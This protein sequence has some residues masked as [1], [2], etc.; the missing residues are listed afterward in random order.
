MDVLH[1]GMWTSKAIAELKKGTPYRLAA[2]TEAEGFKRL[3]RKDEIQISPDAS[4]VHICTNNTIEGS[5]WDELP[6]TGGV[7]LVADMSSNIL[8]R[9][10]DVKKFGADFRRRAEKS[11]AV[12]MSPW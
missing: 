2:S 7:P 1:T 3:P 12:G 4:Y 11:R 8:S 10:M 5:E 6:E 9:P